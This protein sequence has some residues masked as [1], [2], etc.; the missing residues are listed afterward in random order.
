M[1]YAARY[2]F[3]RDQQAELSSAIGD[4]YRRYEAVTQQLAEGI[5]GGGALHAGLVGAVERDIV[6]A[7]QERESR[8]FW[9]SC[10][11]TA[12]LLIA[13]VPL[14]LPLLLPLAPL[15]GM[16]APDGT[17]LLLAQVYDY[18]LVCGII[19]LI[20]RVMPLPRRTPN[21]V[22]HA[23]ALLRVVLPYLVLPLL[24]F[25]VTAQFFLPYLMAFMGGSAVDTLVTAGDASQHAGL[26]IASGVL[27]AALL[28]LL[29]LGHAR[30]D[31]H[32]APP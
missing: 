4:L 13:A 20:L 15:V 17:S 19:Y 30:R 6:P 26:G 25:A 28:R 5:P 24:C 10:S 14:A 2:V 27:M 7:Y 16:P 8:A 29:P 22:A 1:P 23:G 11:V 3:L 18:F 21:F 12:L 32:P 31:Q 9:V